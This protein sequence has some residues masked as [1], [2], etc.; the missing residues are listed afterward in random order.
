MSLRLWRLRRIA[1]GG[2]LVTV[3][4]VTGCA[5]APYEYG[6]AAL[7]YE[8]RA[9][10]DV[11]SYLHDK[12]ADHQRAEAY[13]DLYPAYGTYVAGT[14]AYKSTDLLA[15]QLVLVIPAHIAGRI[16][17]ARVDKEGDS[18]GEL[19]GASASSD[20][21]QPEAAPDAVE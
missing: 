10:N 1:F 14:L 11:I 9:T 20:D 13:K 19:V 3:V 17:A 7:Y 2:F 16:A 21:Q 6:M 5:S 18:E 8:A 12:Q 15:A 4:L